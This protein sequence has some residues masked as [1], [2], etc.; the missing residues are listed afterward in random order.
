MCLDEKCGEID[1]VEI[2]DGI[3]VILHYERNSS[4]RKPFLI[5]YF[6]D[7]KPKIIKPFGC[8]FSIGKRKTLKNK[9]VPKNKTRRKHLAD[10]DKKI[11]L[12]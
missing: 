1:I 11:I 2:Y 10:F 6:D 9:P 5:E 8:S 3:K 7:S 12:T 4:P